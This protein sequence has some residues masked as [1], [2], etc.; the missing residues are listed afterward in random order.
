M[1][2]KKQCGGLFE[3]MGI[4]GAYMQEENTNSGG[5]QKKTS[6]VVQVKTTVSK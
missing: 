1:C 3:A 4:V 6:H 5:K 2:V